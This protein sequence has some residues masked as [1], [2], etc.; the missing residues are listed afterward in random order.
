MEISDILSRNDHPAG[1]RPEEPVVGSQFDFPKSRTEYVPDGLPLEEPDMSYYEPLSFEEMAEA[2]TH[3][4]MRLND[5][6]VIKNRFSES[7][8]D[9]SRLLEKGIYELSS[10]CITLDY[11]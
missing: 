2:L 3:D 7:Y 11:F 4:M 8:L 10:L 5:Y 1:A 9:I 6:A